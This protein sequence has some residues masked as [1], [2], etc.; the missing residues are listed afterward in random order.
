MEALLTVNGK[1]VKVGIHF[2][3]SIASC[4]PDYPQY[5][6]IMHEIAKSPNSK[7]REFVALKDNLSEE[8]ARLLLNDPEPSV[9]ETILR[10]ET[11]K[12]VLTERDIDRIIEL[13]FN[14]AVENLISIQSDIEQVD[15]SY[16]PNAL[17]IKKNDSFEYLL[18]SYP[19]T[20]DYIKKKLANSNDPDISTAAKS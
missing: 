6:E 16:V 8:T 9:L 12:R 17:L 15:P 10:S 1:T 5:Q 19:G 7:T 11:A 20:P 18:A 3:E 13:G 14:G 4:L 2:L